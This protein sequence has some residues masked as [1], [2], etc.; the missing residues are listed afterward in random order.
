MSEQ[1][2]NPGAPATPPVAP[3]TPPVAPAETPPVAG[4]EP[5]QTPPEGGS[6]SVPYERFSEV[7]TKAKEAEERAAKAEQELEEMRN[8][9]PPAPTPNAD[10]G[11]DIDPDVEKM[12]DGFAKKR[13]YLTQAEVDQRDAAVQVKQDVADLTE[14]YKDSGI[15]FDDKAVREYAQKNGIVIGS[16]AGWKSAYLD[17]NHEAIIEAERNKAID[18][19]KNGSS[20]SAEKPGTPAPKA[21]EEPKPQGLKSRVRAARERLA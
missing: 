15:P 18:S 7:N 16:K 4:S 17:M 5:A 20:S 3:A 13:G 21:P 2:G 1:D 6:Q 10:E 8:A 12:L 19:F 9:A 14:Q 11:D